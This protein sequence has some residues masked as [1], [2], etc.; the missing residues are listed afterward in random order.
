MLAQ[1]AVVSAGAGAFGGRN[2]FCGYFSGFFL[3]RF[4]VWVLGDRVVPAGVRRFGSRIGGECLRF[5]AL[6]VRFLVI[7][8]GFWR[9]PWV[10]IFWSGVLIWSV[11]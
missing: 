10:E 2:D 7:W 11:P 4:K 6:L 3:F 5:A 1:P 8:V 9:T